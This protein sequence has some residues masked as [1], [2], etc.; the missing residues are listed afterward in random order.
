[1][2]PEDTQ[3]AAE[4]GG[5]TVEP[6]GRGSSTGEQHGRPRQSYRDPK[7]SESTR[8]MRDTARRRRD[9]EEKLQQHL[10]EAREHVPNEHHEQ[11]Q[12]EQ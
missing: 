6:R 12:R 7:G 1:M 2:Q 9:A 3:S 11:P 8:E 4:A 10:E 5:E